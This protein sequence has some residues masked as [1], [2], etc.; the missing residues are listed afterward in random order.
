MSF[1]DK[2]VAAVTPPESAED[3][4]EARR[5]ARREAVAG[6]WLEQILN[7]HEQIEQAFARA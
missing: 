2:I 3:R 1:F 6:D 5:I 7:H 4:A